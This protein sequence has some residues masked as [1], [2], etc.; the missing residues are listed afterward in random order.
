MQLHATIAK[1][2]KLIYVSG[3]GAGKISEKQATMISFCINSIPVKYNTMN[4][5]IGAVENED[6]F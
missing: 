5:C 6:I 3:D 4:Y 2:K 1:M